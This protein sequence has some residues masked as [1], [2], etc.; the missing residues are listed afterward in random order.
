MWQELKN[1]YHLFTAVLANIY[2]GFPGR[3]LTVIGVT[4]TDGKTTTVNIIYTILRDAGESVSMISTVSANIHGQSSLLGFHVT[5][6]RF[7]EIQKFL[8]TAV[9][10]HKGNKQNYL[11]LEVS[12]HSIDQYRVWGIPFKIGVITNITNEHLDYH[13]TFEKYLH[14]KVKLLQR[15]K[16]AVINKDDPSYETIQSK[17]SERQ[18]KNKK[19]ITF[20]LEENADVNPKSFTFKT[21][22]L[23]NYNRYNALAAI[24]VCR[25]LGIADEQ[26][27]Q[28]L[29]AF[30]APVGR[31]DN[32]ENDKGLHI[33]VD[34]AHTP[35]ALEQ[36]LKTLNATKRKD[37]KIISLIGAEGHRDPSKRSKMGEVAARYSDIII[38]TAVDPRGM[39]DIINAQILHGA[40]KEGAQLEKTVFIETDRKKAV[41]LAINKLAGKNDIVGLF[42]KGHERSMNYD[43]KHELPWSEHEVVREAF[44][45]KRES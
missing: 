2:Y 8:A 31:L 24:S 18:V 30:T 43:G 6:P 39:A 19:I 11:V 12:S 22:L 34:Y 10:N 5:T 42:G 38:I 7:F 23:G 16:I 32:I 40:E 1:I 35:N 14:T 26:I 3:K 17:I 15:A 28:S 36:V 29:K 37:A 13:K 21:G 27:R 45:V 4:G 41:M 20:G 44:R 25:E 33:Y 9:K